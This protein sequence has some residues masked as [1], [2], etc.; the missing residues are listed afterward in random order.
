MQPF[1]A[2]LATARAAL[3]VR[4][5][6]RRGANSIPNLPMIRGTRIEEAGVVENGNAVASQRPD[7]IGAAAEIV[8]AGTTWT[9]AAGDLI[10]YTPPGGA[11]QRYRVTVNDTTG[12]CFSTSDTEGTTLR[13]HTVRIL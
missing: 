9:P 3:A 1:A 10:E 12:R 8:H 2:A 4:V 7:W 5:T 11:L 6:Y 13:I